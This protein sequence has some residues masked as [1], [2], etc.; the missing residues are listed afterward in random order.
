MD[1]LFLF[2]TRKCNLVGI[3]LKL[4]ETVSC[5]LSPL[6]L[7]GGQILCNHCTLNCFSNVENVWGTC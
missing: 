4:N 5:S 3:I 6:H 1:F 2:F 7:D